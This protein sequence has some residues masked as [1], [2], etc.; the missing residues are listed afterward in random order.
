MDNIVNKYENNN[1]Y[2]HLSSYY[3]PAKCIIE[4][5]KNTSNLIDCFMIME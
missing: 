2:N 1:G 4:K 3:E 5:D